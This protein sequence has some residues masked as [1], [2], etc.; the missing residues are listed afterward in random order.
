M[1][2]DNIRDFFAEALYD[3]LDA[4]KKREFDHHIETCASCHKE[5]EELKRTLTLMNERTRVEPTGEE[6]KEFG[7]GLDASLET[8]TQDGES[9]GL[10]DTGAFIERPQ[11]GRGA[12]RPSGG[13][14]I[15]FLPGMRPA[16][17]YGIAAVLLVTFGIYMGR[18]F[19]TG[20]GVIETP[21]QDQES[22][23]STS[24]SGR[25]GEPT[26]NGETG[27]AAG[28]ADATNKAALAYLERSRNLLLGLT[29]LDAKQSAA[30]DLSRH[31]KVSRELY[32]RGNVLT[33][34]L[35][36][37]SQQQLRQLVQNLQIILLQLANM[38]VGRG[39]PA[40]ELVRQGVDS[41]SILLKI[42]LEAIRASL[43]DVQAGEA[44]ETGDKIRQNL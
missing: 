5:F 18:T 39:T 6:W 41:K 37:P 10:G 3:E 20:N 4:R 13:R 32:N 44:G 11:D 2:C 1:T 16:W 23:T 35:N 34:A 24:P 8:A 33:V 17:A 25:T 15:P 28:T 26:V 42:N 7:R 9:A 21:T 38:E 27:E 43:S 29:N 30:I 22:L 14:I 12:G 31:Q 19:F 36:R 40:I